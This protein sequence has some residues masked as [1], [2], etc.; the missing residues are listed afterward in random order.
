M[1]IFLLH[2]NCEFCCVGFLFFLSLFSL[3]FIHFFLSMEF[4]LCENFF[5]LL[6]VAH[7]LLQVDEG[8]ATLNKLCAIQNIP[9]DSVC[10]SA[11]T[12]TPRHTHA[13]GMWP[14]L[15]FILIFKTARA[16]N[17]TTTR[18]TESSR[19]I[20]KR[21]RCAVPQDTRRAEQEQC[22]NFAA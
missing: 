2:E 10:V 17:A 12:H 20:E 15:R 16:S 8:R 6:F 9:H 1:I 11:H 5:D 22:W 4:R 14:C 7:I 3:S 18:T 13:H 21:E 19:V